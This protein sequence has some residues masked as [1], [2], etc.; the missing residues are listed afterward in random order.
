MADL[1]H[2]LDP[3]PAISFDDITG[4]VYGSGDPALNDA[5]LPPSTLYIRTDQPALYIKALDGSWQQFR[6]GTFPQYIIDT[7]TRLQNLQFTPEGDLYDSNTGLFV[8]SFHLYWQGENIEEGDII[9]V[10][11]TRRD[12]A[13]YWIPLKYQLEALYTNATPVEVLL[14]NNIIA[15]TPLTTPVVI[16]NGGLLQ[17]RAGTGLSADPFYALAVCRRIV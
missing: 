11:Y 17:L 9:P 16:A 2:G 3:G 12:T 4:I 15:T 1:K 5:G 13:G 8:T 6:Q 14:D 7:A 10:H